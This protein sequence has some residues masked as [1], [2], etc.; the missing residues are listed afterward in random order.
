M[1]MASKLTEK[2]K[3]SITLHQPSLLGTNVVRTW[4]F[5]DADDYFP[6][7][8]S[9]GFYNE[10]MFKV[11]SYNTFIMLANPMFSGYFS[12]LKYLCKYLIYFYTYYFLFI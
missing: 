2:E 7:Q 11:L 1:S 3:V 9:Q 10:K 4:A 8:T 5:S 6:L 12:L